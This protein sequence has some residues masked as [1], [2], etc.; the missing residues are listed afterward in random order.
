MVLNARAIQGA[1]VIH[2]KRASAMVICAKT[3]V[4]VSMRP[5]EFIRINRNV[6]AHRIIHQAI[7]CTH[8]CIVSFFILIKNL[9]RYTLI[10]GT[11]LSDAYKRGNIKK[12]IY[13]FIVLNK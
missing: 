4:A 3:L 6:I 2:I 12:I 13:F 7:Q 8:V 5:V 9:I 1:T 10:K 11:K